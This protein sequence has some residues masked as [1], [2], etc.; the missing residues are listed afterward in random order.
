ML[1]ATIFYHGTKQMKEKL[2]HINLI[3]TFN[4]IILKKIHG[5]VKL[6][7][8]NEKTLN[9]GCN[10]HGQ[11]WRKTSEPTNKTIQ[12]KW[13]DSRVAC[14]R[15]PSSFLEFDKSKFLFSLS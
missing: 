6:P 15:W 8:I 10:T 5:I 14:Q 3:T 1:H 9:H 7:S 13:E 11:T 2:Q 4:L 12:G